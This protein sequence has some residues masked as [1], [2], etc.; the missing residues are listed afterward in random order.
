[1]Y[2][3]P[4]VVITSI[5]YRKTRMIWWPNDV[6]ENKL[7]ALSY[8]L[9]L[10]LTRNTTRFEQR[11]IRHRSSSHTWEATASQTAILYSVAGHVV[12]EACFGMTYGIRYNQFTAV[13][14]FC[15]VFFWPSMGCVEHDVLVVHR[16]G[17][18]VGFAH[19]FTRLETNCPCLTK[20][21]C[22]VAWQ[23][24]M[25]MRLLWMI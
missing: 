9:K 20:Y 2:C 22:P 3:R 8:Y 23:K 15:Q 10:I 18:L 5:C 4:L 13:K 24:V 12:C 6:I 21:I 7:L 19:L 11:W 16:Y 25:F 17:L 14:K 1:M